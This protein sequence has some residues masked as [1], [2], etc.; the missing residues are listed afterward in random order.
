MAVASLPLRYSAMA[1]ARKLHS[2]HGQ[3][4][5]SFAPPRHGFERKAEQFAGVVRDVARE[6]QL[7]LIDYHGE[8]LRR[9]S[10]D[11]DGAADAFKKY[12]GYDVRL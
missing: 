9:R 2:D 5:R 6:L 7:P 12:D 10:K 3:V 4:L 11:W 1:S 8:L